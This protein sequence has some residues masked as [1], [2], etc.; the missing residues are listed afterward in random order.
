MCGR[1]IRRFLSSSLFQDSAQE[2]SSLCANPALSCT[3]LLP[4]PCLSCSHLKGENAS[5]NLGGYE[6]RSG[7][8][9]AESR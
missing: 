2:P 4:F 9:P 6:D 1:H 7:T 3:S 8:V 5:C